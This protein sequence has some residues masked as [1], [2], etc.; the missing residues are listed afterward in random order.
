MS[1]AQG[2]KYAG[3][4]SV[5]MTLWSVGDASSAYL[6]TDFYKS[7]SKGKGKDE[8]LRLAKLNYLKQSSQI[9]SHPYYWAGYICVGNANPILKNQRGLYYFGSVALLLIIVFT[10]IF[11]IRKKFV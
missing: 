5:V 8:S 11:R 10:G 6:M 9:K 4:P 1:L 2:F 7:L 3:V